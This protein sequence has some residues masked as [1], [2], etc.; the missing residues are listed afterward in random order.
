MSGLIYLFGSGL[1]F[2]AGVGLILAAVLFFSR[3]LR[4]WSARLVTI[5]ALV[6]IAVVVLSAA[7]LSYWY[8]ALALAITLAWLYAQRRALKRQPTAATDQPPE[9]RERPAIDGAGRLRAATAAVWVVGVALELPYQFAPQL[10]AAGHPPLY[11]VGDSVTAGAGAGE[12]HFWPDLLPEKI[13]VH[14][15]AQPGATAASAL[16]NQCDKLPAEGGLVLL[17]IG[18]NDLLGDTPAGQYERDLDQLL[19]RSKAPGRTVLMFELPLPPLANEYGRIQR[20][21]A[22]RHGVRLIPKRILMSVL[23][24]DGATLDSIHLSDAGHQ[25]MAI[26]MWA[27]LEPAYGAAHSAR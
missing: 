10:P 22:A 9:G 13:E 11:I 12:R 5:V 2:F 1:A 7:P 25:R 23:A 16:R 19:A 24:A 21:L 8:Y 26:S 17:E 18:G 20:R 27:I 4:A 3:P 14:N 6:G 15:F